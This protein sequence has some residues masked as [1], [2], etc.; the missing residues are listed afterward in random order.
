M[1]AWAR[2]V[3]TGPLC[4][5]VL[6]QFEFEALICWKTWEVHPIFQARGPADIFASE[7]GYVAYGRAA[8]VGVWVGGMLPPTGIAIGAAAGEPPM[9]LGGASIGVT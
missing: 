6:R 5:S 4:L 9:L 3:A 8:R 1:A 2:S 7:C